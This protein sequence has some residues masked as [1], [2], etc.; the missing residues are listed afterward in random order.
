MFIMFKSINIPFVV[1]VVNQAYIRDIIISSDIMCQYLSD[2]RSYVVL[3]EPQG[4]TYLLMVT[5][6]YIL[7]SRQQSIKQISMYKAILVMAS[8]DRNDRT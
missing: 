2:N 6:V 3:F 1:V 7:Q 5:E 4:D 8:N